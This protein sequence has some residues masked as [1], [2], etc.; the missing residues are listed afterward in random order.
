MAAC[1]TFGKCL[2]NKRED[3]RYDINVVNNKV[4]ELGAFFPPDFC[5]CSLKVSSGIHLIINFLS[6]LTSAFPG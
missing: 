6:L 2:D 1:G 5:H 4:S 3:L